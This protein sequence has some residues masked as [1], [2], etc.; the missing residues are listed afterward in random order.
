MLVASLV[1]NLLWALRYP[2]LPSQSELLGEFRVGAIQTRFPGST[3]CQIHYPTLDTET[4]SRHPYFRPE[5]VVGLADYSKQPVELMQFLSR[6]S[7]PCLIDAKPVPGQ[8]FPIVIFSHGLGGCME[9]YTQ[10]CQQVASYG[11]WV[12]ALEHEDGSGAYAESIS[13][14]DDKNNDNSDEEKGPTPVYYKRPDDTPYSR[15]KV[16]NFR[17]PFLKQRV[18]DVSKALDHVFHEIDENQDNKISD[19]KEGII[20]Q[21]FQAADRSQGV[22]LLGHSFGGATMVLAVQDET[23]A[24]RHPVK[25]L[26]LMDCWAFSLD[27]NALKK[28]CNS[29]SSEN[30]NEK[31]DF[32]HST[33]HLLS[34]AWLTNPEVAEVKELLRNSSPPTNQN[35]KKVASYYVPNSVHASFSDAVC[36]LPGFVA[37]KLWMRGPEE[38]RHE[39]IRAA[40]QA[41]VQHMRQEEISTA[42][43][44]ELV[45]TTLKEYSFA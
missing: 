33:L 43:S 35:G 9:M 19:D 2:V 10:L 37:R 1:K 20:A 44:E 17:R 3:A 21:V 6:R 24:K 13:N 26:S 15:A 30:V 28:G 8:K 38:K 34:E 7:H 36:W 12:V 11:Y 31:G 40:A 22:H 32:T 23:F 18:Q 41:C 42:G 25:S 4:A 5:A 45:E 29:I 16:T 27:D 14:R 39:T